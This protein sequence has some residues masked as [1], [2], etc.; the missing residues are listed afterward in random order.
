[1][2]LA[3]G[4]VSSSKGSMGFDD[5]MGD[6]KKKG[7]TDADS[8]DAEVEQE[9]VE[10][11]NRQMSESSMYTT[12]DE[13]DEEAEGQNIQLGPQFTLKELQEKDKVFPHLL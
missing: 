12:E 5:N 6:E 11:I 1:M 9:S 4:I 13:E 2:S 8:A 7:I 3:V 10:K